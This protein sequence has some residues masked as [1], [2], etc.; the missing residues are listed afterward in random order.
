MKE[1]D[2]DPQAVLHT[3]ASSIADEEIPGTG[4][5]VVGHHQGQFGAPQAVDGELPY[6]LIVS[7]EGHGLV[8]IAD[9]LMAAF[10]DVKDCPAPGV[11]REGV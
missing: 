6:W 5:E 2:T 11:G 1:I 4:V 7:P 3:V 10:G 8:Y 9:V